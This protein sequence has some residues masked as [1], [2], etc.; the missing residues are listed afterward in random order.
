MDGLTDKLMASGGSYPT[1]AQEPWLGKILAL[2][3]M[4]LLNMS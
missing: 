1:D 2:T 3:V 4:A